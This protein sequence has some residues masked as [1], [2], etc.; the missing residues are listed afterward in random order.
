M[1][2]DGS[3]KNPA[4]SCSI[5]YF[6]LTDVSAY[7][8]IKRVTSDCRVLPGGG[9]LAQCGNCGLIQKP[10]DRAFIEE[11]NAIYS[12]YETYPGGCEPSVFPDGQSSKRS[13]ILYHIVKENVDL[14]KGGR[15]IDFGCGDGA[16]LS[17]FSEMMTGWEHF[18]Y[19]VNA[20]G[21]DH[22]KKIRRVK[23]FYS[24]DVDDVP[25]G[26]DLIT[27]I[28][29]LEHLAD[30]VSILRTLYG[31]LSPEGSLVI[32]VPDVVANPFDLIV[33]DHARHYT[34]AT[35]ELELRAYDGSV[36]D[37]L[38]PKELFAVIRKN[39]PSI[40]HQGAVRDA[41]IGWVEKAV[42]WL[43]E[44]IKTANRLSAGEK[45]F[46]IFGTAIS[47]T[48]LNGEIGENVDFHVDEDK[49]KISRVSLGIPIFTP[50]EVPE[51]SD[52]YMPFH[53]TQAKSIIERIRKTGVDYHH[54]E[55]M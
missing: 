28:Y 6:P 46:G 5:C 2:P 29:V 9:R 11:S 10:I 17:T 26:M 53:P 7:G 34:K 21:G 39:R 1:I 45:P 3:G 48:W 8:S 12:S 25:D 52:V 14:A 37:Q 51:G 54:P 42:A 24:K 35:L 49:D 13:R 40:R 38:M 23:A 33:A 36:D 16:L 43:K 27:M 32:V 22:V 4:G 55:R 19:D 30:P 20:A 15:H 31:K 47:A 41:D 44:I 18:G 50:E